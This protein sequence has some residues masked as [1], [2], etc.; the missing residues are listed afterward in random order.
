[1]SRLRRALEAYAGRF[2]EAREVMIAG[3]RDPRV[4]VMPAHGLALEEV[5]YPPPHRMAARAEE[6]RARRD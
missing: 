2:A 3:I 1:M 6:A 5:G 4:K